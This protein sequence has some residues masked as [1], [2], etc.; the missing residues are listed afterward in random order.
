MGRGSDYSIVEENPLP[1]VIAAVLLLVA[2][3]LV[4]RVKSR[5]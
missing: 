5:H 1:I 2:V 3:W 4:L